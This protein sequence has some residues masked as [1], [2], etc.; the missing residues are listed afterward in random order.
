MSNPWFRLYA[1]FSGDPVAQ[2]LAFED[3]RHYIILLCMKCNGTLDRDLPQSRRDA[4]ISRGLGLDPASSA[5]AKRRLMEVGFVDKN[6]QPTAWDKRQFVS[7]ISTDRVRKFRKDK[8]TR[9]VSETG[10]DSFGN[11]PDTEQNRTDTESE[12]REAK[13]ARKRASA[14][15]NDFIPSPALE[16]WGLDLGLDRKTLKSETEKFLDYHRSKGSVFKDFDAAWR[17]WIRNSIE[18]RGGRTTV[19]ADRKIPKAFPVQ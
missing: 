8:E 19:A 3:Q 9:N 4:I 15:P 11:A 14:I 7:D 2:S 6:W 16:Q 10:K 12:Q 5:E 13:E 17:T 1:E 18:Y